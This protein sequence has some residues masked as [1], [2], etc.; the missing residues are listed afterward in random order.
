MKLLVVNPGE[1]V[2]QTL[3]RRAAE[4]GFTNGAIVSLIGAIDVCAISNMSAVDARADIVTEYHH[5]SS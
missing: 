3:T 1:E 5:P 4:A 2:I